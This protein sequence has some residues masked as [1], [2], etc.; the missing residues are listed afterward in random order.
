MD[1][2]KELNGACHYCGMINL[3]AGE[4]FFW[5]MVDETMNHLGVDDVVSVGMILLGKK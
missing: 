2:V 4:L 1:S 3:T 5:V